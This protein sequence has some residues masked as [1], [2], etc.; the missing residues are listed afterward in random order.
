MG[1]DIGGIQA[2]E[3]LTGGGHEAYQVLKPPPPQQ[4][5]PMALLAGLQSIVVLADGGSQVLFFRSVPRGSE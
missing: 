2:A 1:I 4:G 3:G 5:I